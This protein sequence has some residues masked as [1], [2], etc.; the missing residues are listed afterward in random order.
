M[1]ACVPLSHCPPQEALSRGRVN[2][3]TLQCLQPLVDA[4]RLRH[5]LLQELKVTGLHMRQSSTNI[6]AAFDLQ[7]PYPQHVPLVS[8]IRSLTYRFGAVRR[9]W[10]GYAA[11]VPL[12]TWLQC[13]ALH[14]VLFYRCLLE[15]VLTTFPLK[16]VNADDQPNFSLRLP[17]PSAAERVR[18]QVSAAYSPPSRKYATSTPR[19]M[20]PRHSRKFE[21]AAR[22]VF[23]VDMAADVPPHTRTELPFSQFPHHATASTS[24]LGARPMP[25]RESKST[26]AHY[27]SH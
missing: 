22:L 26:A 14:C 6:P 16:L 11:S 25:S 5:K 1:T 17:Q 2:R 24:V 19:A 12:T 10:L 20:H 3:S 13:T 23:G 21:R 8:Q 4:E 27:T 15:W 7:S 9:L 18:Q